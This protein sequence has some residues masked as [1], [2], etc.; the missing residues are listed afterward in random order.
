VFGSASQDASAIGVSGQSTTG[1]GG[2]FKGKVAHLRLPPS[3]AATHPNAGQPGDL[4][5]D[6][7]YRL[8]FCKGGASWKQSA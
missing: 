7:S 1:R 6:S 8:W 2:V 4:F 5:V 3:N